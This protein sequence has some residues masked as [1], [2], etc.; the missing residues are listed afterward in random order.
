MH[1]FAIKAIDQTFQ[2]IIQLDKPFEGKVFI[3]EGNFY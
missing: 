3:F 2:D 1:K